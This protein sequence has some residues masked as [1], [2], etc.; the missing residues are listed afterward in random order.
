MQVYS[1]IFCLVLVSLE[2]PESPESPR[3]LVSLGSLGHLSVLVRVAAALQ[4]PLVIFPPALLL[5][6]APFVVRTRSVSL[7]SCACRACAG[8]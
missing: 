7:V 1:C 8:A 5:L 2:S 4:W 3:S 6:V